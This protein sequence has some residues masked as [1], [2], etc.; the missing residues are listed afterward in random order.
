MIKSDRT[1]HSIKH[2]GEKSFLKDINKI[3]MCS[4][5]GW[6]NNEKDTKKRLIL[7]HDLKMSATVDN[8][9]S[10]NSKSSKS[11]PGTSQQS[12]NSHQIA[13][14]GNNLNLAE[15]KTSKVTQRYRGKSTLNNRK[16]E[17][18]GISIGSKHQITHLPRAGTFLKSASGTAVDEH[19]QLTLSYE[20]VWD[21]ALS[22]AAHKSNYVHCSVP[23]NKKE[24]GMCSL[25]RHKYSVT[26]DFQQSLETV[27]PLDASDWTREEKELYHASMLESNKDFP[28]VAKR[29]DKSLNNILTYYY[30]TYKHFN[31]YK[32]MK[33]SRLLDQ[34][35]NNKN[36]D[37]CQI[38]NDG[39]NLIC[40]DSCENAYHLL[41]IVPPLQDIPQG[42]WHC[43]ECSIPKK[44]PNAGLSG[45]N[46]LIAE[47]Q[48]HTKKCKFDL[49]NIHNNIHD[50]CDNQ[51][52]NGWYSLRI[53]DF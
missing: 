20:Q 17:K 39:G 18:N 45:E 29:M 36:S 44:P 9:F 28:A 40:C 41:C 1:I 27:S 53:N 13:A 22:E 35:R 34:E 16:G 49:N 14:L 47:K 32:T 19:S 2:V 23:H 25:H 7:D 43:A 3:E 50:N 10:K 38:C 5:S 6:G 51:K 26:A 31:D 42:S 24:W 11:F 52:K 12:N 8:S 30:G 48:P 4:T 46:M 37:E 15:R 21:P 33:R